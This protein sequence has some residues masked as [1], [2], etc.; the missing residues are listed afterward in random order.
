MKYEQS[1]NYRITKEQEKKQKAR[2]ISNKKYTEMEHQ[3][4]PNQVN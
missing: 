4:V 1:V 3:N 2:G